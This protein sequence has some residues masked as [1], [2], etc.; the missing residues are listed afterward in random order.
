MPETISYSRQ[1][2][3]TREADVLVVGGGSAGL[4]A[5]VASARAGARTVLVEQYGALGGTGSLGLVGPFMTCYSGDGSEQLI[6]GIFDDLVRRMVELG[7]AIHPSEIAPGSPYASF[8]VPRHGNVTPYDPEIYK[9]VADQMVEESGVHLM[10][11]TF[12]VDVLLDSRSVAGAVVVNKSGIQAVRARVTVDCT[13]DAD[14]ASR[15]G[16]PVTAGRAHDGKTQPMS[17][18]FRVGNVDSELVSAYRSEHPGEPG[19]Y[20]ALVT[21]AAARGEFTIPRDYVGLYQTTRKDEWRVNTSR[22]LGLD[23]SRA[24]DLTR[25]AVEGRK[26]VHQLIRFFRKYCPGMS[27]SHVIDTGM[28][29]GVRESRRIIG[30][31]VLDLDD[32]SQ[33]REFPDVI[34]RCG[35]GIDIHNPEGVGQARPAGIE[36]A[37][38]Y[39]I[40]YRAL[41]PLAVE[42]LLVAGRCL[43]ASHE[44]LG[45]V[46]V[47]PPCFATGQAAGLAAALAT[48]LGVSPRALPVGDLQQALLAADVNLGARFALPSTP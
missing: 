14:V 41:L 6:R 20:A 45:A 8:I 10:L 5:A 17:M 32:I 36:A 21:E 2:P 35:Y 15:A 26:Q 33:G 30:E 48:R 19:L 3:V 31:H 11:H 22:I 37:N 25:G 29:V 9:L 12:L 18:F 7:G 23:G 4:A 13:G 16:A 40:P 27:R 1:I 39:E 46:R 24:E 47:M 44:A 28:Q 43:S 34:A 42:Q 38:D